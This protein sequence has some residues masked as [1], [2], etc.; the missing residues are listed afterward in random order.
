MT[1]R[2]ILVGDI[3][4]MVVH[5]GGS[6]RVEG[7]DTDRVQAESESRWGLKIERRKEAEFARA[8]AK[9]GEHVL[10]DIRLNR[11]RAL[12]RAADEEIIDVQI[13]AS[14]TVHVPRN[15]DVKV[16]AG[17]DIEASGLRGTLAAF[18]GGDLKLRDV[19]TLVQASA[20][21][22]MDLE[23][24]NVQ[25]DNLKFAAGSNLRWFIRRLI[26]VTY[27]IDD[28]GGYW[29]AVLG[30]GRVKVRLQSGGDVTLVTDQPISGDVLG[31]IERPGK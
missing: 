19:Q 4:T 21:G 10:F 7:W 3:S 28:L 13:G 2:S 14:G 1:H 12:Q 16:Y 9:V 24:E 6:V 22:A 31:K 27:L 25:G 20:G 18:A 5:A 26:D 29:E 17:Q 30:A 23:C 15:C 8:R 11:P